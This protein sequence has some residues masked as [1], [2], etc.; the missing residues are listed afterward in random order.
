MTTI[1]DGFTLDAV[2]WNPWVAMVDA[3]TGGP[4]Q[5]AA[6]QASAPDGQIS[7]YNATM[8]HDPETFG[9]RTQLFKAVM[10][11][12]GGLPRSD[13][14]LASV[15][16][17]YLNGCVYCAAI[18]ARIFAQ[19]THT[20]EIIQQLFDAGIATELSERHRAIVDYAAKLT[21]APHL[22]TSADLAPLRAAGLSDLEIL[23]LTNVVALFAWYN[24]L[25]EALGDVV[26]LA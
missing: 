24:R 23:D 1:R 4:A 3:A 9:Q 8:A 21:R 2:D 11:G 17:S 22:A 5:V 25:L 14:E 15:A 6:M 20:P 19:L 13:R 26:Y 12:H 7:T 18:H 10:Y 16:V